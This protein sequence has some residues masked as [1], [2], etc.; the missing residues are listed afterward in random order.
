MNLM[1][2]LFGSFVVSGE[3]DGIKTRAGVS[4]A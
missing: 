3:P 4:A 1:T 2:M